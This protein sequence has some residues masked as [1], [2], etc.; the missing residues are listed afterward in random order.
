M[1]ILYWSQGIGS[2]L[3]KWGSKGC[4]YFC[5]GLAL[6][7]NILEGR[8]ELNLNT[9][10]CISLPY[11]SSLST[12]SMTSCVYSPSHY[13]NVRLSPCRYCIPPKKHHEE[14][15]KVLLTTSQLPEFHAASHFHSAITY[16]NKTHSPYLG[17]QCFPF[18][19]SS[20]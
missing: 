1:N 9:V 12:V 7:G 19:D 17:K 18:A 15:Y 16:L 4:L 20:R 2:V 6:L 3:S 14:L 10:S 8:I 11:A 5:S 13:Q